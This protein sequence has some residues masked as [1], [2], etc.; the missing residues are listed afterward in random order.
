MQKVKKVSI[1]KYKINKNNDFNG[2]SR[3]SVSS[4]QICIS[5][6]YKKFVGVHFS[7]CIVY[8]CNNLRTPIRLQNIMSNYLLIV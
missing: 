4:K 3:F 2:N 1:R 6:E 5:V 7:F 8:V